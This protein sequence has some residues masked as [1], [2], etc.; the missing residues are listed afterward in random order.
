MMMMLRMKWK[1]LCCVDS[2]YD[3]DVF[4]VLKNIVVCVAQSV[5]C[6]AE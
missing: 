1:W 2:E 4:R 6:G 3:N 5:C